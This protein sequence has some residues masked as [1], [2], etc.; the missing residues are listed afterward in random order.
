MPFFMFSHVRLNRRRIWQ[1]VLAVVRIIIFVW[2]L[3]AEI[4]RLLDL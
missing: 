3:Y 1:T 2:R 4:K